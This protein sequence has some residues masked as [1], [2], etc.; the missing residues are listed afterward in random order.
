MVST[1]QSTNPLG[2]VVIHDFGNPGIITGRA[3]TVLSGGDLV[4]VFSG[5]ATLTGSS[6]ASFATADII[7]QK[8]E[9]RMFFNGI[10]VQNT[11]S[12]SY[13]PVATKGLYLMRAGE[14]VSGGEVV[15]HNGSGNVTNRWCGG[16]VGVGSWAIVGR[17]FQSIPSGTNNY[18]VISLW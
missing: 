8:A 14:I 13:V 5:T 7:F 16:G 4:Q 10:V 15:T 9:D 2:A 11:G 12:N 17:A 3:R 18:G 6:A 1:S